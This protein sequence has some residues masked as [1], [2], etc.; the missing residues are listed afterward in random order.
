MVRQCSDNAR[1]FTALYFLLFLL[2]HEL[3]RI[4]KE[5]DGSAKREP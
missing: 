2:Y 3:G 5:L 1:L 4:A